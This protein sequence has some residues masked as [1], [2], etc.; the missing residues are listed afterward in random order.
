[1]TQTPAVI[2]ANLAVSTYRADPDWLSKTGMGGVLNAASMLVALQFV[3]GRNPWFLPLAM[4]ISALVAGYFVR[5]AKAKQDDPQCKL[6]QWDGWGDLVFGGLTWVAVQF[7]WCVLAAI[8]ITTS[9]IMG[10]IGVTTYTDS[11]VTVALL[12][13]TIG[14][15]VLG[16]LLVLHFILSYLMINFAGE[17]KLAAAFNLAKLVRYFRLA[18]KPMLT[19]WVLAFQFQ[20]VSLLVPSLLVVGV[21]FTPTTFFAS[22]LLG[23]SLMAQVWHAAAEAEKYE[24]TAIAAG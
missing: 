10:T 18:P 6:P 9:L 21:L 8:P 20:L 7:A 19:A 4:A 16:T 5:L 14:F 17:E 22:Q 2:D 12:I 13:A 3:M 24:K 23:I 1:M 15:T 11:T